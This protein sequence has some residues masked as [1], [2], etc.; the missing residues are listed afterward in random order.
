MTD[1]TRLLVEIQRLESEGKLTPTLYFIYKTGE[2]GMDSIITEDKTDGLNI[3]SEPDERESIAVNLVD[4]VINRAVKALGMYRDNKTAAMC[5]VHVGDDVFHVFFCSFDSKR[6]I[7]TNIRF[8]HDGI[9]VPPPPIF[10]P[11]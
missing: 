8:E 5:F 7:C 2:D 4:M 6:I 11:R 1:N 10:L 9:P 3:T